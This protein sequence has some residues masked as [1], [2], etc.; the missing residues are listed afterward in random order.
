M[1][2]ILVFLQTK[3]NYVLVNYL[4]CAYS[5]FSIPKMYVVVQIEI[6]R[7]QLN[8]FDCLKNFPMPSQLMYNRIEWC[9]NDID[10]IRRGM[11]G[12]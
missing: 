11:F 8:S 6:L 1:A 10:K 4:S 7:S 2:W 12:M 9:E 5:C 3:K